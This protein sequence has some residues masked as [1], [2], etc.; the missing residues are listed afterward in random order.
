MIS[1]RTILAFAASATVAHALPACTPFSGASSE[2]VDH[3]GAQT[4]VKRWDTA[5]NHH[6]AAALGALHTDDAVTVNRFGTVVQG[7]AAVTK[8]LAFL[9]APNGPFG[10]VENPAQAILSVRQIAPGV[11]SVQ[12]TWKNPVMHADG[13]IDPDTSNKDSWNDMIVSFVLVQRGAD[14]KAADVDLHNVEQM[15]LPFSNPKQK[16]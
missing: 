14:W 7:R 2:P 10:K 11:M 12:T 4:F 6:D 3:A 13:K 15:D 9:H 8:A 16:S 5:W 1:R